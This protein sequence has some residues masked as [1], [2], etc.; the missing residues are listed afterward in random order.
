MLETFVNDILRIGVMDFLSAI[1][2]GSIV[3]LII[4]VMVLHKPH[5]QTHRTAIDQDI[6]LAILWDIRTARIKE[7]PSVQAVI[8]RNSVEDGIIRPVLLM[9]VAEITHV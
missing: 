2:K 5:Y 3:Y 9:G 7:M 1:R 4:A 6:R 8:A